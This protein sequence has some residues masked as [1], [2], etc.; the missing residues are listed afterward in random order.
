MFD[1]SYINLCGNYHPDH[2]MLCVFFLT[3]LWGWICL[4]TDPSFVFPPFINQQSIFGAGRGASVAKILASFFC[5][6]GILGFYPMNDLRYIFTTYLETS[7]D[8]DATRMKKMN[9]CLARYPDKAEPAAEPVP[10]GAIKCLGVWSGDSGELLTILQTCS[11][12]RL[13]S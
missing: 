5:D 11:N 1:L 9:E 2:D 13:T 3:F 12:L 10:E 4:L 7:Q 8:D 6:V